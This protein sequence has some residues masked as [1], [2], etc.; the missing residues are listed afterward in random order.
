[1][2]NKEYKIGSIFKVNYPKIVYPYFAKCVENVYCDNCDFSN[3]ELS[4]PGAACLCNT[5]DDTKCS[6]GHRHDNKFVIFK[7]IK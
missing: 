2:D 5:I 3:S 7:I 1:M 6:S 4:K